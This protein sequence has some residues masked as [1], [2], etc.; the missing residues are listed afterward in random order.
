MYINI[1]LYKH[2]RTLYIYI[3]SDKT[4]HFLKGRLK[5]KSIGNTSWNNE[6]MGELQMDKANEMVIE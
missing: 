2:T 6:S 5:F 1:C 3:Y 4:T